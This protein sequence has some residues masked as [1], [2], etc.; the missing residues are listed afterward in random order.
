ML[1]SDLA[2]N[3]RILVLIGVH[4]S[5]EPFPE[6]GIRA[7]ECQTV[8]SPDRGCTAAAV[9]VRAR[10]RL[11]HCPRARIAKATAAA[12]TVDELRLT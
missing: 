9:E 1:E 12:K 5:T 8:Q 10:A 7:T 6:A 3:K 4:V 11:S 2:L